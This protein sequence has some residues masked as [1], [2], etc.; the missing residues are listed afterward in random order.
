[1]ARYQNEQ[2]FNLAARSKLQ[3]RLFLATEVKS[4]C[5]E[6]ELEPAVHR[7]QKCTGDLDKLKM[8]IFD[9]QRKNDL[10]V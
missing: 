2:H 3:L 8:E 4:F 1:M 9:W 10:R 5:S 7:V 6:M